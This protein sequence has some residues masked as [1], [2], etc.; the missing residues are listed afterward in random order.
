M[1][2]LPIER[3]KQMTEHVRWQP[4]P[5]LYIPSVGE[6]PVKEVS[7]RH[8]ILSQNVTFGHR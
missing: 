4:V 6:N 7:M 1:L 8:P 2:P 5:V 3:S